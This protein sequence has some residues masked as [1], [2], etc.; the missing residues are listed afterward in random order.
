MTP[1]VRVKAEDGG[2]PPRSS[3]VVVLVNVDRNLNVPQMS[4]DQYGTK[5]LETQA[6][7]VPFLQV[8]AKNDDE[9]VRYSINGI[10][11]SGIRNLEQVKSNRGRRN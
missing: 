5:I 10:T 1:Q 6:L 4:Q 9:Q 11:P 7:G 2:T 8:G 3:A